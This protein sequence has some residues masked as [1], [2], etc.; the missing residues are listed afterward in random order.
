MTSAVAGAGGFLVMGAP[1]HPYH[2][3][4]LLIV[5][6][7]AVLAE[8]GFAFAISDGKVRWFATTPRSSTIDS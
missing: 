2:W 4:L 8:N 5:I 3:F 6:G 1:R 7:V